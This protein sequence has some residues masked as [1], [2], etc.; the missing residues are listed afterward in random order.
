[1]TPR[2]L[3][4]CS[5]SYD[6]FASRLGRFIAGESVPG[7]H[8]MRKLVGPRASVADVDKRT[9][10]GPAGNWIQFSGRP[11]RSLD[12]IVTN[13]IRSHKLARVFFNTSN[14][15]FSAFPVRMDLEV[16]LSKPILELFSYVCELGS[17][18]LKW[19]LRFSLRFLWRLLCL[20]KWRHRAVCEHL[21]VTYL[22]AVIFR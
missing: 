1:M 22:L 7:T 3:K 9:I 13:L 18:I 17:E 8:V 16:G 10:S 12:I 19:D 2:F 4:L 15:R 14:N 6:W 21:G 20:G 5:R 11:V